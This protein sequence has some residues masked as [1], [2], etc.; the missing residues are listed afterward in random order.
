[1]PWNEADRERYNTVR[2]RDKR[3]ASQYF[4]VCPGPRPTIWEEERAF[5]EA[6][7]IRG[8][9]GYIMMTMVNV[10]SATARMRGPASM[11]G[12]G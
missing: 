5:L 6:R 3:G 2:E 9:D 7:L 10:T 1:M 12:L 8:G 4:R 11:E